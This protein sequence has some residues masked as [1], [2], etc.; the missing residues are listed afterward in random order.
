MRGV[1]RSGCGSGPPAAVAPPSYYSAVARAGARPA[2]GNGTR[3]ATFTIRVPWPV[4]ML[5]QNNAFVLMIAIAMLILV[6]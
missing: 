1:L 6:E 3:I 2:S 5:P 4:R